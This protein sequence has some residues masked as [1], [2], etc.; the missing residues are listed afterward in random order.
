MEFGYASDHV[1]AALAAATDVAHQLGL[2][3]SETVILHRSN[4]VVVRI[5]DAVLKVGSNGQR[6][7]REV[8]LARHAIARAGPVVAPLGEPVEIGRFVVSAWPYR[9]PDR[10]PASDRL[11][12]QVLA[13]LHASLADTCEALPSVADRFDDV[14]ALLEDPARTEALERDG[15]DTLL[16]ALDVLRGDADSTD[17][18][19]HA[20]PHDGNRIT[21]RGAV[22]YIDFEA[23]CRGPLEWDVAYFDEQT[24]ELIWPR[25]DRRLCRRLRVAV[26]A[27]VAAYCWRHVSARPGDDEMRW[28]AEHHLV[29]VTA[30]LGRL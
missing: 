12:A 25:H 4:N 21:H 1:T 22:V 14:R 8:V 28:H 15:R 9:A 23:A 10:I 17:V 3:V 16:T 5:G 20:E 11:A 19:L 6:L 13:E 7:R 18:V 24:A 26:S 30:D 2:D 29:A 27:C